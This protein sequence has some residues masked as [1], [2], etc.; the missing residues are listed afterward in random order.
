MPLLQTELDQS[1]NDHR[2]QFERAPFGMWRCSRDG[3]IT[4]ANRSLVGLLG[5][6]SA[7]ELRQVD[8][9]TVIFESA[10]DLRWL[11]ERSVDTGTTEL[12][13]TTWRRKDRGRLVVR[14]QA[15]TVG[16]DSIEIVAEDITRLRAVEDKLRQAQ[17][18]EAVGRLASR[19]LSPATTCSVTSR[20]MASSGWRPST[21]TRSSVIKASSC[22]VK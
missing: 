2:R 5:Y 3:A 8:F 13:E 20:R 15:V 21:A 22:S 12:L 17:R 4:H 18:M 19:S 1:Q 7:D 10:D 14:L 9:A 16:S 6:R 11:V